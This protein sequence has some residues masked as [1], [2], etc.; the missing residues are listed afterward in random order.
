MGFGFQLGHLARLPRLG[1]EAELAHCFLRP[2]LERARQCTYDVRAYAAAYLVDHLSGAQTFYVRTY[3]RA[4]IRVRTYAPPSPG[5][6]AAHL[7]VP[8]DGRTLKAAGK[9]TGSTVTPA[10]TATSATNGSRTCS[11]ALDV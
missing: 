10:K 3:V 8:N 4:Y 7:G 6:T 11:R 5:T 2:H 9:L 1:Q